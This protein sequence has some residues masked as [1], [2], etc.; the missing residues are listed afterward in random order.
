MNQPLSP[1]EKQIIER[2]LIADETAKAR[3]QKILGRIYAIGFVSGFAASVAK[4]LFAAQMFKAV[5]FCLWVLCFAVYADLFSIPRAVTLPD[6]LSKL[7]EEG[8]QTKAFVL[9]LAPALGWVASLLL[10]VLL[11]TIGSVPN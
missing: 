6:V 9:F 7:K 11:K 5:V 8:R 3:R 2:K 1:L 4:W 10:L